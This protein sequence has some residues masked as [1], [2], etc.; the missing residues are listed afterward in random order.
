M[1]KKMTFCL[2]ILLILGVMA[3]C[4]SDNGT[5]STTDLSS[6][7]TNTVDTQVSDI[8]NSDIDYSQTL[9]I[10]SNSVSNGRGDWL[11]ARAAEAGFKIEIMDIGGSAITQ[12]LIAEKN[13]SVADLVFGVHTMEYEKMKVEDILL[14]YEP[15]WADEVDMSLGDSEGYYYPIVIQPLVCIIN[16]EFQDIP[17]DWTELSMESRY[18][19][20]YTVR[21]LG[22]TT[23]KVIYSSILIRYKDEN[24]EYG[25]SEEGWEVAK[26]FFQNGHKEADGEDVVGNL[27]S[28]EIPMASMWGSGVIQYQNE[29][30]YQ[31]EIMT[32][33]FGVPYI[34]EQIAIISKTDKAELAKA[35]ADWFGSAQIQ[36]EWS[37]QFGTIPAHPDA[38]NQASDDIISFMN[39]IHS[40]DMDWEYIAQYVDLWVEKA[41]LEFIK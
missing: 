14:K 19:E 11:T 13:N 7:D 2:M 5:V 12:R 18:K 25:I 4:S 28:G 27:I 26:A 35:F 33:D 17:S 39:K 30:D 1:K 6:E 8:Q 3:G 31:F 21:G 34:T 15:V 32:P 16:N 38:L 24:G 10:Y 41:E 37:E 36:A 23:G 22:G 29:Y 40:Q 20:L 9:Y